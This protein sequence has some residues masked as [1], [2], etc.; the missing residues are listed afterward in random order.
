[1]A[2]LAAVTMRGC[3]DIG[4]RWRPLAGWEWRWLTEELLRDYCR[5]A[6]KSLEVWRRWL[7]PRPDG[8]Q[9]VRVVISR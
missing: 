1:M 4:W 8:E 3:R 9:S 2:K 6:F 7:T 5:E